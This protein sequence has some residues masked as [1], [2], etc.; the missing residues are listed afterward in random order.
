MMGTPQ[1]VGVKQRAGCVACRLLLAAVPL[2][3][4][5]WRQHRQLL[6]QG[7]TLALQ[8]ERLSTAVLAREGLQVG[9]FITM[10]GGNAVTTPGEF[11]DR[12]AGQD[13]GVA[14]SFS[15]GRQVKLEP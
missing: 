3:L 10:V 15:S 11:H 9:Q 5:L 4:L 12:I 14:L 1:G 8:E 2:T 6:E 7:A 13:G